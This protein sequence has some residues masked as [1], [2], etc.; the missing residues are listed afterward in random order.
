[1]R[2]CSKIL[3]YG[4]GDF[5]KTW[6]GSNAQWLDSCSASVAPQVTIQNTEIAPAIANQNLLGGKTVNGP[7]CWQFALWSKW[8]PYIANYMTTA[9]TQ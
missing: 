6:L 9:L 8:A 1:M 7:G 5:K 2:D 4:P 3:L